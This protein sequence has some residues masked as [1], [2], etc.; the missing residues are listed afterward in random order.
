MRVRVYVRVLA[1][2]CAC[3]RACVCVWGGGGRERGVG[4]QEHRAVDTDKQT[5]LYECWR[6]DVQGS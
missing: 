6:I 1:C 4:G 3:V 5:N 2:V